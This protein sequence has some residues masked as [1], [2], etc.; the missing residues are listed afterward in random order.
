MKRWPE[1]LL[2]LCGGVVIARTTPTTVQVLILVGILAVWAFWPAPVLAGA[3]VRRLLL[4]Q[5]R[6]VVRDG[7]RWALVRA[8]GA[9]AL[10]VLAFAGWGLLWQAA[11]TVGGLL[12]H[13]TW[14]FV[15][16]GHAS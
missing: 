6:L 5:A 9:L 8:A 7:L 14:S 4:E 12:R 10:G 15:T 16:G 1:A 13:A 3:S 2:A 11:A